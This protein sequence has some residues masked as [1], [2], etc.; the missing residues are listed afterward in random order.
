MAELGRSSVQGLAGDSYVHLVAAVVAGVPQ[1]IAELEHRMC[2]VLRA[3]EPR[4]II[5]FWL[6]SQEQQSLERS[7]L[8]PGTRTQREG[9]PLGLQDNANSPLEHKGF[10]TLRERNPPDSPLGACRGSLIPARPLGRSSCGF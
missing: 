6:Q 7:Q 8:T 2:P 4:T 3:L 1:R 10:K 9:E 5:L